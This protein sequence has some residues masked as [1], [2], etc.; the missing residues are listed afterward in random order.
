[1]NLIVVNELFQGAGWDNLVPGFKSDELFSS[2]HVTGFHRHL[3]IKVHWKL[4]TLISS[5]P[6]FLTFHPAKSLDFPV[7]VPH[8]VRCAPVTKVWPVRYISSCR[9][10]CQ[11]AFLKG[12]GEHEKCLAT[13]FLTPWNVVVKIG[14]QGPW[15]EVLL[16][17][18]C[19]KDGRAASEKELTLVKPPRNW[20]RAFYLVT[21]ICFP[22]LC[23]HT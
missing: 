17:F 1:M 12:E 21:A 9:V 2:R 16:D 20:E 11:E 18:Q 7:P 19:G 3:V 6:F 10:G 22:D 8:S 23:S 14:R 13:F 5:Q 4:T 15:G